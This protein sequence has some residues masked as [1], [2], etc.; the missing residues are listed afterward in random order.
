MASVLEAVRE[1]V[2]PSPVSAATPPRPSANDLIQRARGLLPALKQ[3]AQ[4][5]ER[6]RRVSADTTAM[7]REA[8]LY[9]IM[10]PERWG[11]F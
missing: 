10:L 4:D 5:T 6:A 11:G 7:I 1:Q 2:R 3:R 9:K 8:E